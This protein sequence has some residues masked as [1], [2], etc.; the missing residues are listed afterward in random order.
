[1]RVIHVTFAIHEEA[2]FNDPYYAIEA[3]ME[4]MPSDSPILD[5][6][7]DTEEEEDDE[8]WIDEVIPE[9]KDKLI[10]EEEQELDDLSGF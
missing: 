4:L 2:D 8:I 1:M 9:I 10:Q 6:R 3:A 7:Y 5:W